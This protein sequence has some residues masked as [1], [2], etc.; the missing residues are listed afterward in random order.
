MNARARVLVQ[1]ELSYD[2]FLSWLLSRQVLSMMAMLVVVFITA[3][4]VIYVKDQYR[5]LTHEMQSLQLTQS[6]LQVEREQL[7][8]EEG[9]WLAQSRVRQ[10]AEQRLAMQAPTNTYHMTLV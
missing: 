4:S 10:I 8:L 5:Q 1:S 9:T 3:M 6:R 2:N 7:L